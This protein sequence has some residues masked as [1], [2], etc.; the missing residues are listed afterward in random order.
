[1]DK[2]MIFRAMLA[3]SWTARRIR[4]NAD[5]LDL[6]IRRANLYLNNPDIALLRDVA[7]EHL[8]DARTPDNEALINGIIQQL[9]T[10]DGNDGSDDTV[11]EVQDRG[12]GSDGISVEPAEEG[13]GEV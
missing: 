8:S 4:R 7:L 13:L 1:M 2:E 6:A 12:Q 9:L 11:H 10:E 3:L 5:Q